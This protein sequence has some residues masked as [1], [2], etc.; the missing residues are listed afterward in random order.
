MDPATIVADCNPGENNVVFSLRN[1]GYEEV[2][3]KR[4]PLGDF[5]ISY[6]G[7]VVLIERKTVEDWRSSMTD[8]RLD[9]QRA[10]AEE[11]FAESG[12]KLVY[13]LEGAVPEWTNKCHYGVSDRALAASVVK[14]TLRDG[15]HVIHTSSIAA[16]A[17]TIA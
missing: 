17:A 2:Q 4:L 11:L 5:Q 3:R 6:E 16:T 1:H 10:R 15:H 9:A 12:V 7:S 13:L 8:G 14:M